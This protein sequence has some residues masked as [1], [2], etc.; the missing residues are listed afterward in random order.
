MTEQN[1][2]NKFIEE[3]KKHPMRWF[4]RLA[5]EPG[6]MLRHTLSLPKEKQKEII[7][8]TIAYEGARLGACGFFAYQIENFF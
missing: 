6:Y 8:L 4:T 1:L 2:E 5:L 7:K 3:M